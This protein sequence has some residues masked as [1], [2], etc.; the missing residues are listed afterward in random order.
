MSPF[1]SNAGRLAGV[2]A[3]H[4]GAGSLQA[5]WPAKL[6]I[7]TQT[8]SW[9]SSL[10]SPRFLVASALAFDPLSFLNRSSDVRMRLWPSPRRESTGV[11]VA[12]NPLCSNVDGLLG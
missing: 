8:T 1:R 10:V 2:T 7:R 3:P 4:R 9:W 11:S 6:S 5:C 12:V